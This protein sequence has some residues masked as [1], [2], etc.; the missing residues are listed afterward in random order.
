MPYL[1]IASK[2]RPQRKRQPTGMQGVYNA[3][4]ANISRLYRIAN[5]LCELCLL[6][7]RT[8]DATPGG[9]KGVTD[10]IV[11]VSIGGAQRDVA[12]WLS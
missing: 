1:P 9:R 11:R 3:T 4:W 12:S 2:Q 5:P 6:Q 7:G 10:H 8:T